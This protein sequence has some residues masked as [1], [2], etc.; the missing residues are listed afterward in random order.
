M[1]D[2]WLDD[3]QQSVNHLAFGFDIDMRRKA[4]QQKGKSSVPTWV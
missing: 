3:P 2:G 1:M 4:R